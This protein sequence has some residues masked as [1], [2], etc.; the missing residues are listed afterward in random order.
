MALIDENFASGDGTLTVRDP[1]G[2][3]RPVETPDG[4]TDFAFRTIVAAVD[5]HYRQYGKLPDATETQRIATSYT[6]KVISS[7]MMTDE[8]KL[9]LGYRGVEWKVD[10]GLSLQQSMALLK[11]CDW[12][13]SRS[14][15]VK[16]KELGIPMA[17]YQAWMKQPL[18]AESY[19][20][21]TEDALGDAVPLALQKLLGNVEKSDQ[22]AIEKVLEITGRWNPAQQQIEDVRLFVIRCMEAIVK[23]VPDPVVRQAIM[24]D[25]RQASANPEIVRAAIER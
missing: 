18:F 21:R 10:S 2:N 6:T 13:D 20:A 15:S 8:F 1:M 5:T 23:H 19:R 4:F 12:T 9:A 3:Y 14:T 16:L 24:A 17:R 7:L 25:I 22:R 11:L